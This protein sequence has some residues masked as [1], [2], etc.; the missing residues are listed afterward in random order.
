MCRGA[1]TLPTGPSECEL[2]R[3]AQVNVSP[4]EETMASESSVFA[5][6][7]CTA[8]PRG[9]RREGGRIETEMCVRT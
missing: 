8:L 2:N 5:Y 4:F 3:Q 6:N 9:Q 1:C 7:L